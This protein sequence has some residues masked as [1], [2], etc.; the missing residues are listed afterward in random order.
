MTRNETVEA[1]EVAEAADAGRIGTMRAVSPRYWGGSPQSLEVIEVERPVPGPVEILVRVR[2]AGVNPTDWWSRKHG[3]GG[4][5]LF[6]DPPILG[7]DVSGVVEAV[8]FGVALFAPGDEVFGMP[9]FPR[10]AGAYA[11]YVTGPP[12]HFARKPANVDHV[13]AAALPLAALTAWQALTDTAQVRPGQRV[14]IH[15]AAGG[16]GHLAVQIAKHLG[17]YVIG[18]ASAAKHE[19]VR[20]LGADEVIDYTKVDFSRELRDVDVV[21]DAI[22]GDYWARSLQTMRRGGTLIS[23]AEPPGEGEVRQAAQ[24]G[25]RACFTLVEPDH[26]GMAAI[27]GMVEARQLRVRVDTVFPLERAAA[28]HEVGEAGRTTGKIVLAVD[29]GRRHW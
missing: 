29:S 10:Q 11:Q 9:R 14:L 3:D 25:V 15:A 24:A 21:I 4:A 23:L 8:G 18:T 28:A 19:F 22:G 1:V 27:A 7:Y 6:G 12:R 17:A 2:A 20:G 26:V 16:V 5:G 13:H